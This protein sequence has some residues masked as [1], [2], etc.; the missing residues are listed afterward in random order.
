MSNVVL[1]GTDTSEELEDV[2][3]ASVSQQNVNAEQ[4][5]AVT[6]DGKNYI[7]NGRIYIRDE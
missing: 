6:L 2:F 7:T 3:L 5:E 4:P 1:F